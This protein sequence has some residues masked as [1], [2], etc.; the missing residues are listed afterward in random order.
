[1]TDTSADTTYWNAMVPELTV[2]DFA[3]SLAFYQLS[4]FHV[5]FQRD[6]PRFAYLILG[7]AQ[8]MIEAYHAEGWHTDTLVHPFGR[9]VNF[10]ID[11]TDVAVLIAT[12]AAHGITLYRPVCEVWYHTQPGVTEGVREFLVQDPDGYLLRFSQYLGQRTSTPDTSTE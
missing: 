4:G 5:R 12:Y 1:M 3:A 7:Q 9:G 11:V 6:N 2:S 10:Q 8:L